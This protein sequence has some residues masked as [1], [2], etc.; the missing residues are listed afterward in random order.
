MLGRLALTLRPFNQQPFLR[1]A[2]KPS[3]CR[4]ECRDYL[5]EKHLPLFIV[6]LCARASTI[7]IS[8]QIHL[9]QQPPSILAL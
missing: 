7:P 4:R 6:A 1:A 3:F 8:G 5:P 2:M 9:D